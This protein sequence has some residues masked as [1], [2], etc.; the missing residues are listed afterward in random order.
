MNIVVLV[1]QVPD[2]GNPR[3]L[4]QDDKTVDRENADLVLN[5]MDEYAIEEALKI[6]ESGNAD[7]V[8][9]LSVG[10]TSATDTIRKALQMGADKGVHV[11]DEAIA[12]SCAVGT[13]KVL[14]GA[15]GKLEWDVVMCGAESTDGRVNVMP[16]MLSELTGATQLTGARKVE[17]AGSDVTIERQ[18]DGGYEVIKGQ[19]PAIISV[20]D[21]INE[22]RYPSFKG[23]MAAKKKPIDE[24]TLADTGV[25]ASE[26]GL[27]N[28]TSEVLE[29]APR[30]P[31]EG[32]VKIDDEG[33]GG[34]KLVEYLV[35]QKLV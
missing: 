25:D 18:I 13:A 10:P 9:V 33:D 17:L 27:A 11:T 7:E 6:K 26:V 5:E 3:T 2:S 12:G 23:I 4:T 1:K 32:G 8:T 22:P 20:W 34:Q 15:L 19:L 35:S 14:A 31:R 29:F 21:T 24:L 28:A 16:A 30:P